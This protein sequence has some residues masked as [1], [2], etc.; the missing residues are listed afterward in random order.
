VRTKPGA[1]ANRPG[2]GDDAGLRGGV[3]HVVR[4]VAAEGGPAG[5][6]DDDPAAAAAEMPYR[7]AAE[8]RG[9]DQVDV[10]RPAP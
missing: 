9:S 8:V 6:I 5:D 3:V 10:Q 1:T 7:L 4:I 2:H